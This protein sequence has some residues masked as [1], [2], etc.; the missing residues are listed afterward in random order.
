MEHTLDATNITLGRVASAAAVLLRGKDT[1]SFE[2]YEKPKNKVKIINASK[3]AVSGKK[4]TD[5]VYLRHSGY[6]GNQKAETL[7]KVITKKGSGEAIRRA[8]Y[9]ML[10]D[11]KLR[12]VMMKNLLIT[13]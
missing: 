9:G 8:V 10:P 1:A 12:A 2:R 3:M 11:N 6:P 5:K 7:A 4:M 13:E